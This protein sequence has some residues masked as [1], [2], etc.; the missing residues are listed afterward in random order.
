MTTFAEVLNRIRASSRGRGRSLVLIGG[1]A[2]SG[3][4]T[5]TA[6]L[7]A[8]LKAEGIDSVIVAADHWLVDLPARPQDSSLF[9]RYEVDLFTAAVRMLLAGQSVRPP[10]YDPPTRRRLASQSDVSL[11]LTQGVVLAEGVIALLAD[12]LTQIAGLKVFVHSPEP[13]R[14]KRL[15]DLSINVKG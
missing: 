12:E 9:Q 10:L 5:L 7:G 8:A 2:R 4:S 3:K 13:V 11:C 6:R 14:R 1:R 15:L